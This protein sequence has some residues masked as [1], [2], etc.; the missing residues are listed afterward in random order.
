MLD[1]GSRHVG[2]RRD[3][4]LDRPAPLRPVAVVVDVPLRIEDTPRPAGRTGSTQEPQRDRK[5][6]GVGSHRVDAAYRPHRHLRPACPLPGGARG[7]K[8]L[9]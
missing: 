8:R 1:T 3:V 4:Q 6:P 5:R 7:A 2:R 9:Q